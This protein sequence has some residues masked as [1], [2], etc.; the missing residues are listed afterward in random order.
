MSAPALA[1]SMPGMSMPAPPKSGAPKQKAPASRPKAARSAPKAPPPAT[2]PKGTGPGGTTTPAPTYPQ[3]LAKPNGYADAPEG[4]WPSPIEP[5]GDGRNGNGAVFTWSPAD[6]DGCG[7]RSLCDGARS[8][9]HGMAARQFRA[10]RANDREWQ[11][12]A[13][14]SWRPEPR[15]RPP[16]RPTR[17]RQGI[18]E[19]DADGD[20]EPPARRRDLAASSD[21]QPRHFDG[22]ARLSASACRRRNSERPRP[23]DRPPTSARSVHGAV[24]FRL[25]KPGP[26]QQRLRLR[27][28][29]W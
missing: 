14:G 23:P 27:G 13:D 20:G 21:G 6:E 9:G 16:I 17:R 18:R 15:R 11:L 24:G 4:A 10:R 25:T 19:R 1:Q 7:I 26:K 8:V 12:D 5:F 3:E 22:A 29:P 28:A 2:G